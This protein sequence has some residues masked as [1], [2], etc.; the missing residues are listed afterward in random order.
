MIR[1]SILGINDAPV[2]QNDEGVIVEAGTL[3]VANSANG[4]ET[5]DSG[6]TFNA[7]GEHTLSL[8]HI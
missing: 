3:T 8:I 1:I 4:N 2:A 5:D 6:S 7:S